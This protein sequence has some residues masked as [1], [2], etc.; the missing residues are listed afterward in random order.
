[1]V[2]LASGYVIKAELG[3]KIAAKLGINPEQNNIFN[4]RVHINR[5]TQARIPNFPML[6]GIEYAPFQP[7]F[8][9]ILVTRHEDDNRKR[10]FKERLLDMRVKRAF[11]RLV[12]VELEEGDLQWDTV[13]R[14]W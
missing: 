11:M 2:L 4:A 6:R 9:Y 8:A 3:M 5:Y 10:K 1:M 13:Y 7:D 14:Y 12:E